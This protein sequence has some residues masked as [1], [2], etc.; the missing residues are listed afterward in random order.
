MQLVD[1]VIVCT[2]V[3][4]SRTQCTGQCS[5]LSMACGLGG[6]RMTNLPAALHSIQHEDIRW[7]HYASKR[8]HRSCAASSR[9]ANSDASSAASG[10]ATSAGLSVT[11]KRCLSWSTCEFGNV[12]LEW[13][14]WND[15]P[16]Y[17][18]YQREAAPWALS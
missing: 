10:D 14:C 18:V 4:S 15:L 17:W 12:L 11:L 7:T 9:S 2:Q 1:M 13:P 16:K 5:S 3:A 6:Q 8:A